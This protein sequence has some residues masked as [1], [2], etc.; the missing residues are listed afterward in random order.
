MLSDVL[1]G[2]D[3]G[4]TTCKIAVTEIDGTERSVVALPTPW[5]PVP[6]GAEID[7]RTLADTVKELVSTALRGTPEG[8]VRG[9]GVTSMGETGFLLDPTGVPVTRGVA[10][11]DSRGTDAGRRLEAGIGLQGFSEHTGLPPSSS[12]T[13]AKR[14]ELGAGEPS[15]PEGYRW[16]SVAE[17]IVRSLGGEEVA[18]RSLA[19][20]T[21][22]LDVTER[23]WWPDAFEW[24]RLPASAGPPLID[25]GTPVGHAT[26][27]GLDGAILTV[28]GHDQPCGAVGSGATRWGDTHDSCGT[29]EALLR[30]ISAS[31]S[32]NTLRAAAGR[33]LTV[34]CHVLPGRAAVLGFF[35]AG[36]ELLQVLGALRVEDVGEGRDALDREAIA[37][38][39]VARRSPPSPGGRWRAAIEASARES[40]RI[41]ASIDEITSST[42]RLVVSGGWARSEAFRQIKRA[43]QGPF[44]YPS[45][46][47]AAARGAALFGGLA[48]GVF[49]ST[50]DFPSPAS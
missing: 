35:A 38:E 49:A 24:A 8:S 1:I 36:R 47:A 27:P 12:W 44:E 29:A 50:N 6:T 34:G 13:I 31:L 28:A 19:S 43:I 39:S 18:E 21:G 32:P 17:W 14:A 9:V 20:R 4:S 40:A 10:W 37:V 26:L 22:F 7:P 5:T 25:A 3:L 41:A 15:V 23:R 33:G 42:Q 45:V 46:R 48:A 11:F 30:G 2:I 16:Q